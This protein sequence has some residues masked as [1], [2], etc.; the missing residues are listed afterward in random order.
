MILDLLGQLP[1][2]VTQ[3]LRVVGQVCVTAMPAHRDGLEVLRAHHRAHAGAAVEVPEIVGQRGVADQIFAAQADLQDAHEPV[4]QF[5]AQ[6]RLDVLR[7][8]APQ[9]RGIA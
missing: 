5:L 8:A 9:M 6:R 1:A 7:V 4:R 3:R 2:Q